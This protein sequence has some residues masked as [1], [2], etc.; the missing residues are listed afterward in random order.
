MKIKI[1]FIGFFV[2]LVS[3]ASA[4]DRFDLLDEKLNQLAKNYPG[5]N[6]KV[7]LSMNGA[8]VQDFV[9]AVGTNNNLNV[10]VDPTLDLK[11]SNSFK[12]VSAKEVF[13]FLC[14]RYDLDISFVGP[15][16]TFIKYLPPATPIKITSGKK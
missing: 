5:I 15:I 11:I 7:E 1:L 2:L 16:M 3:L 14:K 8:T 9:R 10:N 4:Q 12:N 6:E 13:I